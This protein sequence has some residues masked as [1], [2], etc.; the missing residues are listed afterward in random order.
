M[1]NL[2][3][4]R[5]TRRAMA[6]IV[7]AVIGCTLALRVQAESGQLFTPAHVAKLKSVVEASLSPDGQYV[8]YGL[9]VQRQPL[10]DD[11]GAA[12]TELHVVDGNKQSRAFVTGKVNVSQIQWTP[13]GRQIAYV[14]KR[15]GDEKAVLYTIPIDGGESQVLLAH[16]ES[17]SG[18]SFCPVDSRVAF[19]ATQS[20]D[21]GLKQVRDKGFNQEVY[22]EDWRPTQVWIA[23]PKSSEKPQPLDVEGSV[24]F[25][26]WS[27]DGRRL[28]LVVTATSLV[29]DSY[30]F[31]RVKIFDVETGR[32]TQHINN[33][34]KLGQVA[35]GP[36]GK[37]VAMVSAVDIHDPMEGH[38]MVA[39][40]P[41]DGSLQDLT[42]ELDGHVTSI[43]WIK[44]DAICC[45]V[46]EHLQ[47]AVRTLRARRFGTYTH[48][49]QRSD[50]GQ[51]HP[52]PGR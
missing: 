32:I 27:P 46:D 5:T 14:A 39:S 44:D 15:H 26:Q 9:A 18:V 6:T 2:P 47:T 43:A 49:A 8:A 36:D 35:F 23:D 1:T 30:M 48:G 4:V 28:V 19:L 37:H 50:S 21:E 22:E 51:H 42:P 13:D 11:D 3:S 34:G 7:F 38:L 41:G 20:V 31:K 17:I 10:V 29:D 25:V 45:V 40:V 12:W 33:P 52:Q 24:S 16:A